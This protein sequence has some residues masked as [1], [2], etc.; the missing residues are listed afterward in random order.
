MVGAQDEQAFE[1]AL[2]GA[3]VQGGDDEVAGEGGA[4]G[5]VGGFVIANLA[6]DQHLRVLAEQVAGGF[7]EVE[8]A[9]FVDLGLHDAGDDL[10][11]GVFDGDDVAA[12]LG[13]EVAE[14]GVDGGGL[15][16]A[17]GAGEQQQAG[18]LLEEAFEFG[19]GVGGEAQFGEGANA[20]GS[21][22]RRTIFSP[23]TV[24]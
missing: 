17:G 5:D 19:A 6:D 1:Y 2:A 13:G 15:A 14:A 22:R 24:G 21:K 7:G 4:D 16:A 18:G 20:G 8:A 10:L 12:A 11:D 23:V 3:G 9:G